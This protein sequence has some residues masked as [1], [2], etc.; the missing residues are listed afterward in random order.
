MSFPSKKSS[1]TQVCYKYNIC[2]S[3]EIYFDSDY[4]AIFFQKKILFVLFLDTTDTINAYMYTTYILNTSE[5]AGSKLARFL[6]CLSSFQYTLYQIKRFGFSNTWDE[7][8]IKL[9]CTPF[10]QQKTTEK[11]GLYTSNTL[12]ILG[13]KSW[14]I[15]N[16][17]KGNGQVFYYTT[18]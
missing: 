16:V 1:K 15:I 11:V 6:V 12:K 17:E 13:L 3:M 8:T 9:T 2:F 4:G 10:I 5:I 7:K 18:K 14:I